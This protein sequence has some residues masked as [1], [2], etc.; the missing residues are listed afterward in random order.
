MISWMM[1]RPLSV[2]GH[3]HLNNKVK[4]IETDVLNKDISQTQ[5]AYFKK[6]LLFV[7]LFIWVDPEFKVKS[8]KKSLKHA[9]YILHDAED[10]LIVS[11]RDN[12]KV[13]EVF[14]AEWIYLKD[15]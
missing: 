11:C 12:K 13:V 5:N 10:A 15:K 8:V 9:F 14:Q 7:T 3:S 4:R 6:C 1:P 2:Q